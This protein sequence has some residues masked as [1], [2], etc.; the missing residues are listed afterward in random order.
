MNDSKVKII[1]LLSVWE[2]H[3]LFGKKYIEKWKN[4]FHNMNYNIKESDNLKINSIRE[5]N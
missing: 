1:Q 4:A 5:F 2:N 3:N